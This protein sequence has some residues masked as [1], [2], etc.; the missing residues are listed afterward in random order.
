[1]PRRQVPS[2]DV[3]AFLTFCSE[4]DLYAKPEQVKLP[5]AGGPPVQLIADPSEGLACT[6]SA[7]C[8]YCVKSL[9][10]MQRHGREKHGA[11]VLMEVRH[12]P[13]L[14]QRIF[15]GTRNS[16]FEIKREIT[17]GVVSDLRATLKAAF[18]PALDVPLVIPADTERERTPLV[19]CMGW[20]KFMPDIRMNPVQR[21]AADQIKKKHS[22]EEHGGL[23]SR[24]AVAI[25]DHMA[26]AS[27]ILDGHPHKLALSKIL[28]HGDAIPR[29]RDNHWRPVSGDSSEYPNFMIQLMRNIVRIHLG[30]PLDFSFALSPRQT[31]CLEDLLTVLRDDASTP[32]KR[33]IAYH[34]LA[35]SLVDTDPEQ[36]VADRWANPIQQA[37]WLRALRADGNFS[38]PAAVTPDLAKFKYLCNSTSLLEA[39]MDKDKDTDSVH[40]DDHKRVARIHHSVLRLGAPTTFNSI[41]EMQQY[42]SSLAFNQK[43]EP[44]VYVDPEVESITIGTETMRMDKLR[45]GIQGLLRDLK[46]R[47]TALTNSNFMLTRMPDHVKDDLANTTRGYS[48]LSEEPFHK[49]R[50]SLF[51]F[52]VECYSLAMVDSSGRIAWNIP[53]IKALLGRTLRVWEPLY[54]LL[55]IATHISCR[56]T[57]FIDHQVCNADRHRNLFMGGNEMFILTGYSKTTGITDRDS[58]TPGFVPKDVAFWVLELLGGGLRTAEAILAGVAYGKEAEHL[59]RTYL[60][61]GG[62]E[63]ITSTKF[64]DNLKQWN[65]DYFD[66]RWG[67]RDFRQGAITMGREF[68]SP[69]D[70]YDQADSILAESADHSTAVDLSHYAVVQGGAP[71]LS[72]NS[73]CKHRW[74]GDQ[75]HSLLGLGPFPP[76]EAIRITKRNAANGTTFQTMSAQLMKTVQTHLDSFFATEFKETLK[77]SISAVLREHDELGIRSR[78]ASSQ[79]MSGYLDNSNLATA[80]EFSPAAS[81]YIECGHMLSNSPLPASSIQSISRSGSVDDLM[82]QS[83]DASPLADRKGKG[84]AYEP[85]QAPPSNADRKGKGRAYEPGQALPSDAKPGVSTRRDGP[86]SID[87]RQSSSI[88]PIPDRKGKRKAYDAAQPQSAAASE[89]S[90]GPVAPPLYRNRRKHA[91]E[92]VSETEGEK[93]EEVEGPSRSLKRLRRYET[94]GKKADMEVISLSS[95]DDGPSVPTMSGTNAIDLSSGDDLMDFIVPDSSRPSSPPPA[96]LEIRERIRDG[97]RYLRKDPAAA[98]KS[99]AQMDALIAVL[100]ETRDVMIAMKTGGGKSMLWMVPPALDDDAKCI[101]VCPFVALLEEQY[102]KTAA[103][104]LRCHNYSRSKDVPDNVQVLF[105]Q[106]EHCSSEAFAS[107]LM[108]PLGKKF[109]RV[110]VDEFHDV[111]NCHPN[112]TVRWKVLAKQFGRMKIQIILLSATMPPHLLNIFVKPFGIKVKDLA[113][114]R[115]STN[116]PEI[117]MHLI[118]VQ[119]IAAHESLRKLVHALK[120]R[121]LDEERMLVFFGSQVDTEFFASQTKCAAYHSNLWQAGNTKAYNLDLWDRGESKVM[122]CTTAFAQG[123]DRSNIRYVVIFRPTYGLIVNNQMMGRAG[124]DG[125]ESHVFFVTD[126]DRITTFRGCKTGRENCIEELD[127]VVHG[128]ECRRYSTMV[129]MDGIDLATRCTEEPRGVPCDVCSPDGLMQR[130]AMEAI[131]SPFTM[132]KDSS[133]GGADATE[134]APLAFVSAAA[135]HQTVAADV[136]EPDPAQPTSQDSDA[137]YEDSCPQITPS[138]ARVLHAMEVIHQ[139]RASRSEDD[140]P[141]KCASQPSVPTSSRVELP[142]PSSLPSDSRSYASRAGRVNQASLSRLARTS[143]L[144]KYMQV[145][146]DHCPFHFGRRGQL[147]LEANDSD[148]PDVKAVSMEEYYAF[149]NAFSFSRFT[150]CFQCCLPQSKNFNAEQP[151]CHAG[152]VYKKGATCPFAGFVFKAVYAMWRQEK[153]RKLLIRDIGGG[154]T[155]S[156]LQELAAWAVK[157]D[158]EEGKYNNCLEAFLWFCGN[159]ER[160]NPNFFL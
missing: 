12:R 128:R 31:K 29:D 26:K 153:F 64:S 32:R 2:S 33:M 159:V 116:R 72:N 55:Y 3:Q 30:F 152:F 59:Y 143:R 18:L 86:D 28:L 154:A 69:E 36:C 24:L 104:G 14:V 107:L 145:L 105:I 122:A 96:I 99:Q 123:I 19:R 44:N 151:A 103:T 119:P 48:F 13:C 111:V 23:L 79:G 16:Y 95:D 148:C 132:A 37:I 10:T 65:H 7:D 149:K 150:Y 126:A 80:G 22:A 138:Q 81:G 60:C 136:S 87:Q 141:F 42:A 49:K 73:M 139:P 82:F 38:E 83:S 78:G 51:F 130:F 129:C 140:D 84:R 113:K 88:S 89:S 46:L 34:G 11:N 137:M 74:L 68:I 115:S 75:W 91:L 100:T 5:A 117:G 133:N 57:Q 8:E 114:L 61:V 121:L 63:R 127:D 25:K 62:G 124:R 39:L 131:A 52:L 47:Y 6:A 27:T 41:Y 125:E 50:H 17:P 135:F 101:V 93:V 85:G 110:Y 108:S 144:N 94:S 66:C 76:P 40:A 147:V 77:D 118:P 56:G 156:T 4:S 9:E 43:K 112:R 58:C 142:P 35:W 71:R 134:A 20:D 160:A 45:E 98:E 158:A 54:H 106:V 92:P 53:G 155:L 67:L 146:K 70:S 15:S 157:E 120:E 97:I 21:G 90:A 1:M 109:S 102:A